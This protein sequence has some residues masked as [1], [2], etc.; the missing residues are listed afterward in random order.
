MKEQRLEACVELHTRLQN[1]LYNG[2]QGIKLKVEKLWS[3]FTAEKAVDKCKQE[4][5]NYRWMVYANI[6]QTIIM[7]GTLLIVLLQE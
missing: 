1:D 3:V 7:L 6:V 5:A 4:S 2:G